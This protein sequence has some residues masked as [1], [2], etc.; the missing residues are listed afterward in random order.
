[1]LQEEED[2]E[3]VRTVR[4]LRSKRNVVAQENRKRLFPTKK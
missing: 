2:G 4:K 3:E 1:M